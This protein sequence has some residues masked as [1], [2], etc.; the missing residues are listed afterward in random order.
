MN[1]ANRITLLNSMAALVASAAWAQNSSL[2]AVGPA[3]SP[4][5]FGLNYRMGFNASVKFKNLGG[6]TL[7]AS[8]FTPSG[9]P[10]NYDD[11]YVYLDPNGAANSAWPYT[12]YWGYDANPNQ[13]TL[14]DATLLMHR[15][16]AAADASTG[17][18]DD[19]PM[20]GFEVTYNRELYRDAHVRLGPEFGFGYSSMSVKDSSTLH[21]DVTVASD[22]Y[23]IPVDAATGYGVNYFPLQN[24]SGAYT[25]GYDSVPGSNPLIYRG[26]IS[27]PSQTIPGGATVTGT[28]K[29]DADLFGF[30]VGPYFEFPISEKVTAG[31]SGG[32]ALVYVNSKFSYNETVSITGLP[33]VTTS[34]SAW[35]D[36]WLPGGYVAGN[37]SVALSD[38]WALTAGAQ[39]EDVGK[40]KQVLDGKKATLDLSQAIFVTLG[41]T[42]SF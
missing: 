14:G 11:G 31:L 19:D 10:Y 7:P 40:Y 22:A 37:I 12:W 42:Y 21:S 25:H 20:P 33:T 15:S 29:F 3:D 27:M 30:R 16:S 34:N 5:R 32:F 39:F 4:N 35:H 17:N 28:R 24:F 1:T 41:V 36:D 13:Y 2:D 26:A 6:Y 38:K 18:K 23:G 9:A 8:R